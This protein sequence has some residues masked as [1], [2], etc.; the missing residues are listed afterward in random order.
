MVTRLFI[1][2]N[3]LPR[4]YEPYKKYLFAIGW[5]EDTD[6]MSFV[7]KK[8]RGKILSRMLSDRGIKNRQ[9]KE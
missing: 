6:E 2:L 7:P 4:D 9:K 3:D 8:G 1:K 5:G